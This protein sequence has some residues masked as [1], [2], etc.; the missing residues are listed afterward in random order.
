MKLIYFILLLLAV[1][2][3]TAQQAKYVFYFIGD[4][5]GVNQ[6][7]AT[8]MY[9]A[10]CKGKIGVNPLL[11][12]TFPVAS[13]ATT[14]SSTNSIT[15]SAA[16]G[17]ALATGVKT[18][19]SSIGLNAQGKSCHSIAARAKA[20]GHK[21][22]VLTSVSI[23]HATPAAFYA[24]QP[25]R[26]MYYEIAMDMLQAG[27]DFYGGSGF[28]KRQ[29]EIINHLTSEGYTVTRGLKE[30]QTLQPGMEKVVMMPTEGSPSKSLSYAIDRKEGNLTLAQLVESAVDFLGKNTSK[31]FFLMAEGGK[32]DWACHANDAGTLM[33][34]VQDLDAAIAVAYK[35]YQQ[36]P[37]ET[38]IV[39]TADHETG[40][41][42]LGAKGYELHLKSLQSQKISLEKLSEAIGQLRKQEDVPS[43]NAIKELLGQQLGFW[44]ELRPD[45]EQEKLLKEA[46]EKSFVQKKGNLKVNLYAKIE[47]LAVAAQQVIMQKANLGWTTTSHTA[48]YVPVYAIGAGSELFAGKMDN[49]E[50][51]TRIGRAA[52]Y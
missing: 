1:H 32:I 8:E 52:G 13:I 9:L 17:T 38:L 36:H 34:E 15:D 28:L 16:A 45:N 35:F 18:Y 10:E 41:L 39:V 43:W 31:G 48:G 20:A 51:P 14:F 49:T 30:F 21:V 4:G 47:P 5:M 25:R 3:I 46:Y 37:Q 23:D 7:N 44:K 42:G 40:G 26:S 33:R 22:G 2:P 11:F 27:F 12:T 24:H 29:N 6:I 19:N 50:I